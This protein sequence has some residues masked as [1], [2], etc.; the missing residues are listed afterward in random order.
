MHLTGLLSRP[1]GDPHNVR[2]TGNS[3]AIPN[4][5]TFDYVVTVDEQCLAGKE[6]ILTGQDK[7][8]G[9]EPS[10][11]GPKPRILIGADRIAVVAAD[12]NNATIR[13][14]SFAAGDAVMTCIRAGDVAHISRS[15]AGGVGI[16]IIR[17]NQLILAL[18]AA[19]EVPLG[20]LSIRKGPESTWTPQGP[21]DED[22]WLEF[23]VGSES[24]TLR[25][26]E[27]AR[28][29]SYDLYVERCWVPGIPG[30]DECVGISRDQIPAQRDIAMRSAVLLG[31][32][33]LKLTGWD[34][35]LPLQPTSIAGD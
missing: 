5:G 7:R 31:N 11:L 20:D 2:P 13:E 24:R 21:N 29:G 33:D 34:S 35:N 22:T 23:T 12:R 27:S 3:L 4:E 1:A 14:A 18:G 30:T 10:L 25:A 8:G 32:A 19:S 16:S 28:L 17:D 9:S 26:R 6:P 15:S